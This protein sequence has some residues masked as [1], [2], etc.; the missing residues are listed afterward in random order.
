MEME[1]KGIKYTDAQYYFIW[2]L[3][4]KVRVKNHCICIGQ[5]NTNKGLSTEEWEEER[6]E[7]YR[8]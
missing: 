7:R 2:E 8:E 5:K 1:N 6:G 4:I 3:H